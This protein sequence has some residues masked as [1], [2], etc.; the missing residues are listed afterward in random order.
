MPGLI[1]MMMVA[2]ADAMLDT[3]EHDVFVGWSG[4]ARCA[5]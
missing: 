4:H 3:G 2:G 1:A 5:G